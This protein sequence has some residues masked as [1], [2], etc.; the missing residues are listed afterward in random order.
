MACK[1]I[2]LTAVIIMSVLALY[3]PASAEMEI[4][5]ITEVIEIDESTGET[6]AGEELETIEVPEP[7]AA[8]KAGDSTAKTAKPEKAAEKTETTPNVAEGTKT[9][10]KAAPP[11]GTKA[12]KPA[13]EAKPE[14]AAKA[15]AKQ[16]ATKPE[17]IVR[18]TDIE[19][20]KTSETATTAA[21]K[22]QEDIWGTEEMWK[23]EI[24]EQEAT[25]Y[26]TKTGKPIF[27]EEELTVPD[28]S[29]RCYMAFRL[30]GWSAF[31]KRA[32]GKGLIKC[33]N[34]QKSWVTL[35]AV[36]GGI[37]FGKHEITNGRG[38]FTKV[39]DISQLYGSYASSEAHAG[40]NKSAD[41]QALTKGKVSLAFKGTGKGYD[42]GFSF[43]RFKITP[44]E[45]Q[46]KG[47]TAKK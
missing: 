22:T 2:A 7:A 12:A 34:G 30:K 31:Y 19:P 5:E 39:D 38:R 18:A 4:E 9:A 35:S 40:A 8:K 14:K 42:L 13:G 44:I 15:P 29:T 25:A 21:E 32:K 24:I 36:G 37:T 46:R 1:R 45:E 10:S 16:K 43:G 33:D 17:R 28:T 20:V 3:L 26:D 27:T 23:D 11:K 47:Q 41:A 6:F